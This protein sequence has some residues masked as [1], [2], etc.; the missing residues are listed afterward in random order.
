[1][2]EINLQDL[3]KYFV[4]K[5]LV[6]VLVTVFFGLIGSLYLLFMQT[7]MYKSTTTLLLANVSGMDGSSSSI[8][9]NDITLN[10]KLVSTY[11]EIIKS[12]K[13]LKQVIDT[14]ELDYQ[15]EQ[16]ASLITVG[17]VNETEIIKVTVK[18]EDP[19]AAMTIANE[20][21]DI[22]CKEIINF[23]QIQ[24]VNIIDKAELNDTPYNINLVKQIVIYLLIGFVA[25]CAIV[26]IMYYFDTTVKTKEEVEEKVGLPVLGIIPIKKEVRK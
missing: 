25:S 26:F 22:F 20:V 17:S 18:N 13:V 7:P 19:L 24:N 6:I 9:T 10:Q 1:M 2:E 8:T 16:L 11:R 23:Y 4:S 12:R 3:F 5:I 14:L 15:Y 21:A